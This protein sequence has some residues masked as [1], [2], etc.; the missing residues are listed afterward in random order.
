MG[1]WGDGE[2]GELGELGRWGDTETWRRGDT[3]MGKKR[4]IFTLTDSQFPIP[5]QQI[6][7]DK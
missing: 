3:E 1:R 7:N 5:K 4:E 2:L 6:T